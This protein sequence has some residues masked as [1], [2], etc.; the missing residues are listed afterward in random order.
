MPFLQVLTATEFHTSSSVL[1]PSVIQT[2]NVEITLTETSTKGLNGLFTLAQ[3]TPGASKVLETPISS[4]SVGFD[5]DLSNL[6]LGNLRQGGDDNAKVVNAL[7]ALLKQYNDEPEEPERRPERKRGRE[8][9]RPND[10]RFGNTRFHGRSRFTPDTEEP[11]YNVIRG[12]TLSDQQSSNDGNSGTALENTRYSKF[13]KKNNVEN[14]S[15]NDGEGERFSASTDRRTV[16]SGSRRQSVPRGRSATSRATGVRS[17]RQ[18]ERSRRRSGRTLDANVK[19]NNAIRISPHKEYDDI[20]T[21]L[22][23]MHISGIKP[24]HVI[25]TTRTVTLRGLGT[26]R[27]KRQIEP[28]PTTRSDPITATQVPDTTSSTLDPEEVVKLLKNLNKST[29]RRMLYSL[30][31]WVDYYLHQVLDEII[32]PSFKLE[33]LNDIDSNNIPELFPSQIEE[34]QSSSQGATSALSIIPNAIMGNPTSQSSSSLNLC[35][36]VSVITE[37]IYQTL[38]RSNP[39]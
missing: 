23:T 8:R 2:L 31:G 33:R 3:V 34:E 15:L 37:T 13:R 24:G 21:T 5:L 4:H 17:N 19:Q 14:N 12:F 11:K 16:S 36:K 32:E 9:E 1:T 27:I 22:L 7:T 29:V 38:Y 26:E 25:T 39:L 28:E 18:T 35:P 30:H 20:K 10:N 6:D